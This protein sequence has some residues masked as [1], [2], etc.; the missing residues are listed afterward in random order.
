MEN[1]RVERL[2]SAATATPMRRL[3]LL[4]LAPAWIPVVIV[5][6]GTAVTIYVVGGAIWAVF[7]QAV[8]WIAYGNRY[9][10]GRW[11][12]DPWGDDGQHKRRT[13]RAIRE[14]RGP[15]RF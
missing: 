1:N 11:W 14:T 9:A 13:D 5:V 15:R 8:S 7:M 2:F 6:A 12:W 4:L 10:L 3:G